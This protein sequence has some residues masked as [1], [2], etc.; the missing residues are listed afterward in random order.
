MPPNKQKLS[1][2]AAVAKTG[3]KEKK[4]KRPVVGEQAS[5]EGSDADL[6]T[7]QPGS[8]QADPGVRRRKRGRPSKKDQGGNRKIKG[9]ISTKSTKVGP[10][11]GTQPEINVT[12]EEEDT[13]TVGAVIVPLIHRDR[14]VVHVPGLPPP[15]KHI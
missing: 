14:K 15:V 1:S 3:G 12:T 7:E 10:K 6:E 13:E 9:S 2:R 4:K 8:T 11:K 5:E